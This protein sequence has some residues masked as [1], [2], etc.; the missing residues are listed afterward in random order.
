MDNTT[1]KL[2]EMLQQAFDS[3]STQMGVAVPKVWEILLRQQVIVAVQDLVGVFTYLCVLFA[4]YRF[5]FVRFC[6]QCEDYGD[7]EPTLSAIFVWIIF[8]AGLIVLIP[9]VIIFGGDA[10]ARLVNPEYYA[11]QSVIALLKPLK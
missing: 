3:L 7:Q 1:V 10:F 6:D 8:G 5:F 2:L 4:F 9:V 11:L